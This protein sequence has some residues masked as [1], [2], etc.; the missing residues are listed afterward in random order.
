MYETYLC[1]IYNLA[2]ALMLV[3][4]YVSDVVG[5]KRDSDGNFRKRLAVDEVQSWPILLS[6]N[7]VQT[8]A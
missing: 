4:L 7:L 3:P 6:I 8:D 2:L 1:R 5:D